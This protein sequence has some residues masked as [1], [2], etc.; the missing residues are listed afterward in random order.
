MRR[1]TTPT[2]TLHVGMDMTGWTVYVTMKGVGGSLELT[3]DRL[4]VQG[5]DDPTIRFEL[6]QAETLRLKPGKCSVQ[7]RAVK[8]GYAVATDIK[9]FEVGKVLKEGIIYG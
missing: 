1:G 2:L 4:D 6:T 9:Q 7:V 5:G 3:N 8:D